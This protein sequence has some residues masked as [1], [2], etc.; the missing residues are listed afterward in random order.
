MLTSRSRSFL[1]VPLVVALGGLFFSIWNAWDVESVPCFSVGCALYQHFTIHGFSLWWIGAFAFAILSITALVGNVTLG[2]ILSGI[3]VILDCIL[4]CIMASTLPCFA[5]LGIALILAASYA[6]FQHAEKSSSWR[7]NTSTKHFASLLLTIWCFCFVMVLGVT[8]HSLATP[9]SIS[10]PD[11]GDISAHIF[12][13]PSCNACRRLVA[14]MPED[15]GTKAAWYPIA[16]DEQDIAIIFSMWKR[17]EAS[18]SENVS[19]AMNASLTVPPL[20]FFDHLSPEVLF[21]QFR[22]WKN[23]VRVI[24]DGGGMLPFV[25]F[26]GLPEALLHS[27]PAPPRSIP[28]GPFSSNFPPKGSDFLPIDLGN[29][30]YCGGPV[31]CP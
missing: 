5:C 11:E 24:E 12:F 17:L 8:L 7:G 3:G 19:S 29:A 9:W 21:L 4:L 27:N 1:P 10:M 28:H 13:S 31:P 20:S 2:R 23:R 16:E 22:L 25:A 26:H 30:G 18:E 6:A 15:Q 14:E